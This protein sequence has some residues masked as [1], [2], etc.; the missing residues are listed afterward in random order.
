MVASP[1]TLEARRRLSRIGL[2][3]CLFFVISF[4]LQFILAILL[5]LLTPDFSNSTLAT[6]LLSMVPMYLFAFPVYWLLI[7]RIPAERPATMRLHTRDFFVFFLISYALMYATNL[8]SVL[9]NTLTDLILGSSSTAGATEIIEASPL[10]LVVIFA[11]I[12]GPIVE[13]IMFRGLLLPR[14]SVFG[15]RFAIAV[16][17]LLFALFHGNL[18]Q[19]FYAFALGLVFGFVYSKTGRLRYPILLHMLINFCGSVLPLLVF[20]LSDIETL[21]SAAASGSLTAEQSLAHLPGI[22]LFFGYFIFILLA[23]I[24]G[25]VLLFR[26][27]RRITLTP[28]RDPIPKGERRLVWL[29]VGGVLILLTTLAALALSYL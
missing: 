21:E 18:A 22:L 2:A 13:E 1:I 10:Y 24:I 26:Y 16:S 17:A 6:W 14:L 8:I 12:I 23:C 5:M 3:Y 19:F 28:A 7:R 9:I 20:E 25:A 15:E 4:V 29:S 27:S 11:V